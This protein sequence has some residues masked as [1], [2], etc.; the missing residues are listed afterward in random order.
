MSI[1]P[2]NVH[3]IRYVLKMTQ[4]RKCNKWWEGT[5]M[6]EGGK[7]RKKKEKKKE[8]EWKKERI[9]SEQRRVSDPPMVVDTQSY[10]VS[11]VP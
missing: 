1:Q 6:S 7:K 2:E 10:A 3:D 9:P 5:M 11:D 4:W 8:G